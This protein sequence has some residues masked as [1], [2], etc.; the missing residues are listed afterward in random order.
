MKTFPLVWTEERHLKIKE[1]AKKED[2]S[3]NQ[4]IQEAIDEKIAKSK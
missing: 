1:A 4:F 2:K 3:L